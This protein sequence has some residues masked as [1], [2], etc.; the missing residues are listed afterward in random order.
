MKHEIHSAVELEQLVENY[1]FLPFFQNEISGFSVEDHTPQRLWFSDSEDGP[2]EWKGP[3]A[4]SGKCVYGKFYG[5]KAGF[6]SLKWF[7]DFANFRRDGYDFDARYDDGLAPR[8]DKY[9]YDTVLEKRSLLSKELKDL[10]NYHKGGNKGFDTIITRLQM[11]TYITISNFEYMVDKTGKQYGW[12]VARYS[13][14]EE[15]FGTNLFEGAYRC[16][17][18]ESKA[19]VLAHLHQLL[20][21]A[22]DRQLEKLIKGR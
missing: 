20:P 10:C 22:M 18:A 9:I 15:Q 1:G 12:G 7:P 5:G 19:R 14:P 21:Q 8:K 17:P 6:V 16:T 4:S 3:V 2:W 11:Q 13:T